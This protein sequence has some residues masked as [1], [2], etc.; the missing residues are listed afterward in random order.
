MLKHGLQKLP[1]H[2]RPSDH[3]SQHRPGTIELPVLQHSPQLFW[4]PAWQSE[5][6]ASAR[7]E[8]PGPVKATKVGG[9]GKDSD[10]FGMK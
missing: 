8:P 1:C 5:A 3:P 4:L 10:E 2:F 6:L 7:L 9:G